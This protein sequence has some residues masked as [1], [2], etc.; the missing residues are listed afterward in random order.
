MILGNALR[1]D[2][3][4]L[5]CPETG[6][7]AVPK[8]IVPAELGKAGFAAK[9]I[10]LLWADGWCGTERGVYCLKHKPKDW[11]PPTTAGPLPTEED[12]RH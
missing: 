9:L 3:D 7:T 2:C 12:T 4:H 1:Y 6:I 8:E 11:N 10:E 5:D